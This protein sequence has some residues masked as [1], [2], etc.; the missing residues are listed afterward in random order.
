MSK[1]SIAIASLALNKY[2]YPRSD[3]LCIGGPV[4]TIVSIQRQPTPMREVKPVDAVH[5]DI[6]TLINAHS[7][8]KENID[9]HIVGSISNYGILC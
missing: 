9:L 1:S 4:S 2:L 5:P 8:T 6:G 7:T 3:P